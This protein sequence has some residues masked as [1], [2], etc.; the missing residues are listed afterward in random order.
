[1][2]KFPAGAP[3]QRV[4]RAFELLGFRIIRKR[5]HISMAARLPCAEPSQTQSLNTQNHLHTSG[6]LARRVSAGIRGI[7]IGQL[8]LDLPSGGSK[9]GD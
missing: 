6:N 2:P 8:V 9:N 3:K 4:V 7:V 1:M 5:E